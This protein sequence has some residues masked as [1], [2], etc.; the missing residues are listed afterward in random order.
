MLLYCVL[1]L[2][3]IS[4]LCKFYHVVHETELALNGDFIFSVSY[5]NC[6]LKYVRSMGPGVQKHAVKYRHQK[7]DGG[8]NI[9]A[10]M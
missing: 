8:C 10:V 7:T 4:L 9:P 3:N 5:D 1:V 6:C 2:N